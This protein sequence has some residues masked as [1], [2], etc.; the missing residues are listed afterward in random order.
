MVTISTSH[1]RK[2]LPIFEPLN[3]L[4]SPQRLRV[5]GAGQYLKACHGQNQH[6]LAPKGS[7]L[8]LWRS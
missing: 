4:V 2:M 7:W 8:I 3:P 5:F 1:W 6:V